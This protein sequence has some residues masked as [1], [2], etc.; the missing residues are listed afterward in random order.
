MSIKKTIQEHFPNKNKSIGR[1]K[2][3]KKCKDD[4]YA[5]FW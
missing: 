3:L 1:G 4:M 5:K 2:L